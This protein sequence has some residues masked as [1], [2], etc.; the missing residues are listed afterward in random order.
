MLD[1]LFQIALEQPREVIGLDADWV[2]ERCGGKQ[3]P[4][5][6]NQFGGE[7]GEIVDEVSGFLISCAMPAVSW[8]NE[9]IFSA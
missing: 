3:F 8:P 5:L 4:Q 2:S 7:R 1:D 9:A 6:V